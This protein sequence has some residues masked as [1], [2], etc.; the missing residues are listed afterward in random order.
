[1]VAF[2]L[3]KN[4]PHELADIVINAFSQSFVLV[5]DAFDVIEGMKSRLYK[6]TSKM[7]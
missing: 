3:A 1:M 2:P 4:S 5:K 6:D 7:N